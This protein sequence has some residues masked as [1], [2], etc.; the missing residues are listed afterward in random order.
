MIKKK[1]NNFERFQREFKRYQQKFGLLGYKVYFRHEPL[2]DS[3]ADITCSACNMTATV[4]FSNDIPKSDR[5]FAK[6]EVHAKHEALHLLINRLE[7][8][9]RARYVSPDTI[10]EA[11]E[12]LVRRLETLIQ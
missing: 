2:E 4:R 10:Y 11:T 8:C 5:P 12:E 6:P 3:F 9:S 7:H 1:S